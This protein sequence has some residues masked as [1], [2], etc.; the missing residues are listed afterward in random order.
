MLP[1]RDIEVRY[2]TYANCA[3]VAL[4][5]VDLEPGTAGVEV[6]DERQSL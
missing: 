3:G 6:V 4:A 5:V 1:I 2:G